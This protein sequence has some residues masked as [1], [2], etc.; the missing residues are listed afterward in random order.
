MKNNY[1]VT[2]YNEFIKESSFYDYKND[3]ILTDKYIKDF[4]EIEDSIRFNI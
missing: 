2:K 3:D 1:I 4:I